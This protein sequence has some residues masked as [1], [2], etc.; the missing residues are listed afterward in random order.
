MLAQLAVLDEQLALAVAGGGPKYVDRHRA[1][2]KLTARERIEALLDEGSFVELGVFVKHRGGELMEGIEAPGEG[3][4]TGYGT[5]GGRTGVVFSQ[6]FTG[7][8]GS[9]GE[10]HGGKLSTVR[11]P[12]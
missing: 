6:A 8:A 1:R 10:L 2:G 7:L 11:D 9:L 3:V 5:G 4:G 12:A